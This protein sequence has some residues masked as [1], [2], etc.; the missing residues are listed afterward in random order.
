MSIQRLDENELPAR[1]KQDYQALGVGLHVRNFDEAITIAKTF[2][3]SGLFKDIGSANMAVVKILMGAEFGLAPV[4]AM[5]GIHIVQG[6]AQLSGVLIAHLINK[7][8]QYR[9]EILELTNEVAS[10]EFFQKLD[11]VWKSKG[12]E[13][14]TKADAQRQGTQNM[15]KFP[16]NMLY[17][18]AMSNGAKFYCPSVFNGMPVYSEDDDFET[19]AP[20]LPTSG[21]T[22]DRIKAK[23]APAPGVVD[24]EPEPEP[25]N[26]VKAL[27]WLG[28]EIQLT[29]P[30][31]MDFQAYCQG[32]DLDPWEFAL[33]AKEAGCANIDDIYAYADGETI[34]Q[35]GLL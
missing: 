27:E 34:T 2:A 19:N 22:A 21:S 23:I 15:A 10:I 4:A 11:G 9:C 1:T 32:R 28:N 6:K 20:A 25:T 18:R 29:G 13:T 35:K 3:A 24:V 7:S 17:N 26:E 8:G 31:L 30:G 14:F 12:V 33:E 16:K 5:N